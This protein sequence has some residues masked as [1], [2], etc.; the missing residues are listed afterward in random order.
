M[1]VSAWWVLCAFLGGGIAGILV[2]AMMLVG[3][4]D[5]DRSEPPLGSRGTDSLD[6]QPTISAPV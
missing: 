4:A 3:S 1:V 5:D 2:M 6:V